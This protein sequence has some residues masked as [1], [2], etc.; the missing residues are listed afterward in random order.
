VIKAIY[1]FHLIE[2]SLI[3]HYF[4]LVSGEF[5]GFCGYSVEK[6]VEFMKSIGFFRKFLFPFFF[7]VMV[8]VYE[9]FRD[10]LNIFNIFFIFIQITMKPL[11]LIAFSRKS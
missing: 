9:S 8:I 7:N 10:F 2:P 3:F 1:L 4:F 5:F 11:I 6:K